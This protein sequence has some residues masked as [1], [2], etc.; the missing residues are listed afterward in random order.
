MATQGNMSFSA[1]NFKG[2]GRPNAVPVWNHQ[3]PLTIGGVIGALPVGLTAEFGRVV[4]V[5]P[6]EPRQFLVGMPSGSI[7]KGILVFDPV[8]AQLDPAMSNHYFEGR[9]AT[10]VTFGLIQVCDFEVSMQSPVEG[11]RVIFNTTD[12]RLGFI[13]SAT[14]LPDG[15]AELNAY[16]YQK[17]DPNGATLFLGSRATCL[18]TPPTS[19]VSDVVDTPV[20]SPV[21]GEVAAGTQVVLTCGTPGATI[22]FTLDGTN[23]TSYSPVYSQ[24]IAVT[25]AV[26]IKA[27]ALKEDMAPSVLLTAAYTI[28]D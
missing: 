25:A 28:K 12:G 26:T 20:A 8:I 21:A 22:R 9:P 18:L 2:T 11:M 24:P 17:N 4:S 14:T 27:V 23:P 1:T 6:N 19:E 13:A 7:P 10:A 3:L 5:M 15:W 16:V